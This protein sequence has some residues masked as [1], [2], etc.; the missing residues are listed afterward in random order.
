MH[1]LDDIPIGTKVRFKSS[2]FSKSD[3]WHE[4]EIRL[5]GIKKVCDCKP[6]LIC[7]TACSYD[8]YRDTVTKVE[9]STRQTVWLGD[10]QTAEALRVLPLHTSIRF[11]DYSGKTWDATVEETETGKPKIRYAAYP[12]DKKNGQVSGS[13]I[14]LLE[15]NNALPNVGNDLNDSVLKGS[16]SMH[17]IASAYFTPKG[18]EKTELVKARPVSG[19]D[20]KTVEN[21]IR[22][23]A[24]AAG[25]DK[26][27]FNVGIVKVDISPLATTVY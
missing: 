26:P 8:N 23:E 5:N 21:E 3:E 4:G 2:A 15:V 25:K 12:C 1:I 9:V 19:D 24:N 22:A 13:K 17:Y 11:T 20:A 18:G 7:G 14:E 27:G 16:A 10:K 6:Y